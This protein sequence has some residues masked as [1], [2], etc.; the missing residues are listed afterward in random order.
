VILTALVASPFLLGALAW[1]LPGRTARRAVFMAAGL[2]QAALAGRV[3]VNP[4][5]PEWGG[6][7]GADA[8][9]QIFLGIVTLLFALGAVY[10]FGYM[11]LHRHPRRRYYV[12]TM[13][14]FLGSMTLAVLSRHLGLFWVA[15]EATTLSSAT[16]IFFDRSERSLEAAWKYLILCSVGIA[17]AL[18][19]TFFMALAIPSSAEGSLQL[20]HLMAAA[21]QMAPGWLKTAFLFLLVGYGTKMGLAPMHTWLPDA[22]SEAPSPVSALLSGALL[23]CAFLGILRAFQ[24]T[25]AAG[26]GD[27][28][29]RPL[30]VLGFVSMATAAAFLIRQPDYKRLL[31]YSSVEHMGI[32]AVGMGLGGGP[33]AYGALLHA[34]NH[35]LAKALLFF[36]AGAVFLLYHSKAVAGVSGLARRAPFVAVLFAA[37]F[38]AI[39]GTPPFG[40]FVS[41]FTIL[42]AALAGGHTWASALFLLLL[43]VAFTA[44]GAAFLGMIFG[45]PPEP[46]ESPAQELKGWHAVMVLAPPA[47]L[48]AASLILGLYLPERLSALLKSA[49]L[50]LGGQG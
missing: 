38:L 36:T 12:P 1:V 17:L 3:I 6:A 18:A 22:H 7:L 11:G 14:F 50:L 21:P 20:D 34:L 32:L 33:A 8:L 40:L 46:P 10:T 4:P 45:Q 29:R 24:V 13:L 49:A 15:L 26:L 35:S 37:G 39:T 31:A 25:S 28:A 27:F 48:A 43:A 41:E 47:V 23:N 42:L 5:P 2:V 30:L 16:L 9:G 44:M 19:G